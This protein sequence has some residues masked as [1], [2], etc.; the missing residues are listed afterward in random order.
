MSTHVLLCRT[1]VEPKPCSLHAHHVLHA[2]TATVV[3]R[4][5]LKH[6]CIAMQATRRTCLICFNGLIKLAQAIVC[7]TQSGVTLS[8]LW[9]NAHT[10]HGER[11]N[12][13]ICISIQLINF[14][15]FWTTMIP[16]EHPPGLSHMFAGLPAG[17]HMCKS[18]SALGAASL[19]CV[20]Y[21]NA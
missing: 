20:L 5:W 15:P 13:I 2:N 19:C 14:S 4:S 11:Q 8:P 10:L 12:Y 21:L 17:I 16:S 3:A 18:R 7:S 6:R 9:L 1:D